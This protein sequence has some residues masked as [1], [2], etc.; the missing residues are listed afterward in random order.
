MNSQEGP[1]EKWNIA[2]K[3]SQYLDEVK[4]WNM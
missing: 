2:M 4:A 1:W 3:K